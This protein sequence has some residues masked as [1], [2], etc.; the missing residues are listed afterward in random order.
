MVHLQR[1]RVGT[2]RGLQFYSRF[3]ACFSGAEEAWHVDGCLQ[4]LQGA[5]RAAVV[6]K[7]SMQL[8]NAVPTLSRFA[9]LLAVR[10]HA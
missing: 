1:L 9:F 3:R 4:A 10:D 7:A 2:T 8:Q 5:R 6:T